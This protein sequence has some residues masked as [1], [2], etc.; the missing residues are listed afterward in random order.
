MASKVRK[1]RVKIEGVS[2]PQ[3]FSWAI[4]GRI[5]T[6]ERPGGRGRRHS[7]KRLG[8]EIAF[9]KS[10][11]VTTVISLLFDEHNLKDYGEAGLSYNHFPIRSN[12]PKQRGLIQFDFDI[13]Q[14]IASQLPEF[15]SYLDRCLSKQKQIYCL[16]LDGGRDTIGVIMASYFL[17][18][19]QT[20]D[21][22]EAIAKIGKTKGYKITKR[23]G[24][25]NEFLNL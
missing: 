4:P 9:L 19:G 17:H 10:V 8:K 24:V 5:C 1:A 2:E 18:R 12:P 21:A 7:K 25:V 22:T 15:F 11:G 13:D 16:H 20:L 3:E 14:M 23:L 6:C